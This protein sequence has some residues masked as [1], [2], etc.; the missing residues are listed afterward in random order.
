MSIATLSPQAHRDPS[1]AVQAPAVHG[2]AVQAP[3]AKA[4]AAPARDHLRAVPAL[5]L[6]PFAATPRT[7]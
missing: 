2:A 1:P 5:D 4:P 6:G 7:V 3:A